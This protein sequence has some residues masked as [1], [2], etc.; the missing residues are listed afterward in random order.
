M[1]VEVAAAAVRVDLVTVAIRVDL[2]AVAMRED[3][4]AAAMRVD[5][6]AVTMRVDLAAEGVCEAA[7]EIPLNH[8][9]VECECQFVQAAPMRIPSALG[10][11]YAPRST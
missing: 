9:L 1:W 6:A 4:P 3:Q 8:L 11:L 2:A 7:C 5:L 10:N